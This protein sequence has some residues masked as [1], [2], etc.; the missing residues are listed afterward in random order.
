MKTKYLQYL[1]V[2]SILIMV[3]PVGALAGD[4]AH[5]VEIPYYV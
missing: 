3:F 4:K 5:S 1:S 2:L